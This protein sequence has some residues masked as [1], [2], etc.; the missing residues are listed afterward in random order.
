MD[1]VFLQHFD[2]LREKF[3]QAT[4]R[5]LGRVDIDPPV[6]SE[7]FTRREYLV[8]VSDL[9]VPTGWNRDKVTVYLIVPAGFPFKGTEH[10]FTDPELR[11]ADGR[12]PYITTPTHF[13]YHFE[14]RRYD[15]L[16]W[17]EDVPG[18]VLWFHWRM[19]G[20]RP[21]IHDLVTCVRSVQQRF[22]NLQED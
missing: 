21:K 16:N 11:L 22:E 3:P 5:V 14:S 2:R 6:P 15:I 7:E 19:H 18:S 13:Y 12:M 8:T 17:P 20:W 4:A 9:P 1:R 10:F